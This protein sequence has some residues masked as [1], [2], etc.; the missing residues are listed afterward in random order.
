[1]DARVLDDHVAFPPRSGPRLAERGVKL[2]RE[3]AAV[4]E[5]VHVAAARH[6]GPAHAG[7]GRELPGQRFRDLA[8]LAAQRLREVEGRGEREVA[9]LHARRVLEAGGIPRDV[10][11]GVGRGEN[12]LPKALLPLQAHG[13][14]ITA[15]AC[16]RGAAASGAG[17]RGPR[18]RRWDWWR[19]SPCAPP[20]ASAPRAGART[21]GRSRRALAGRR[22]MR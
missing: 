15:P 12:P 13:I 11:G 8:R 9:E 5:Q 21:R 14:M 7:S 20:T 6:L 1:V 17:T 2:A 18:G 19:S 22:W 4:E 10:A 3:R 16:R